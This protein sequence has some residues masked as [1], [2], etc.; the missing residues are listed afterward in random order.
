MLLVLDGIIICR[1]EVNHKHL[2]SFITSCSFWYFITGIKTLTVF[3]PV[4]YPRVGKDS[5]SETSCPTSQPYISNLNVPLPSSQVVDL[6][7][8]ASL[9]TK[10]DTH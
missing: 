8:P 10:F 5:E 7:V 3:H 1:S 6:C 9:R 2:K 4:V